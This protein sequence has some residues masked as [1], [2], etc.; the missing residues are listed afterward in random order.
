MTADFIFNL[1]N[2]ISELVDSKHY[3][4]SEKVLCAHLE[5][6]D[7]ENGENILY[8]TVDWGAKDVFYIVHCG[9]QILYIQVQES[10]FT[11]VNKYAT[12]DF[13]DGR[14]ETH[15]A[16]AMMAHV[17]WTDVIQTIQED[18]QD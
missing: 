18:M 14:Y 9:D 17:M 8:K 11:M 4:F 7:G 12:T 10:G 3:N 6:M 13:L 5:S 1:P 16:C 2:K 15:P